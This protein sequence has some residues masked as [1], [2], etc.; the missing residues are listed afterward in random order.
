[1]TEAARSQIEGLIERGHDAVSRS[2]DAFAGLLFAEAATRGQGLHASDLLARALAGLAQVERARGAIAE[3]DKLTRQARDA[4]AAAADPV[5]VAVVEV[6]IELAGSTDCRDPEAELRRAV[7]YASAIPNESVRQDATV[8]ALRALG[9]DQRRRGHYEEAAT[10]LR[11]ALRLATARFG[12]NSLERAGVLNELGVVSKFTG[13]FADAERCYAEVRAIQD[14]HGLAMSADRA[15]LLH[16][17]GGLD[18]ARGELVRAET[19]ARQSVE[20][21][22]Q[23]LGEDHLATDLDR[24]ALAAILDGNGRSGE[25]EELLETSIPRLRKRLGTHPEVAVAVNNLGAIFQRAGDLDRAEG[26]YREAL[27]IKEAY[28]GVQSPTLA[29]T[30][31]NLG[32]V[33]RRKGALEEAAAVYDRAVVLLEGAVASDHPTLEALRRNHR[34]T[35]RV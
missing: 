23:A 5:P 26:C 33:L 20:L 34:R 22:A 35:R 19:F 25:A 29:A 11:D 9:S 8:R 27:T 17:L 4:L 13:S 6:A 18:H 30:L 31:N 12:A 16:N 28:A 7:E 24:I 3:A 15:T 1:M 32:T 14:A 2:D 10:T 21:H